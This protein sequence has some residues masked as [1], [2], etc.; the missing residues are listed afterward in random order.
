MDANMQLT[1]NSFRQ[2]FPAKI[3]PWFLVKSLTF[4]RQLSNS[5]TF[6]GFPDKWSPWMIWRWYTGGWPFMGGLLHM[7]HWGGDWVAPQHAQA[8]PR[9]TK[10]NSQPINGQCTKH[11]IA[12]QWSVALRFECAHKGLTW[13]CDC[14]HCPRQVKRY[15]ATAWHCCDI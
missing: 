6:P 12:V 8:P 15:R 9:C 3:F 7:V 10:C 13:A 4:P 2:L 11:R 14:T 1:I 5:P